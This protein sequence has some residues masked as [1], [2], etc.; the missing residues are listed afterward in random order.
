MAM[1]MARIQPQPLY[2]FPAPASSSPPWNAH[3][4]KLSKWTSCTN[5]NQS[6]T[7]LVSHTFEKTN[8]TILDL[9]HLVRQSLGGGANV[10]E[11]TSRLLDQVITSIDL[12]SFCG[13]E[14]ELIAACKIPHQ[15]D[16]KKDRSKRKAKK[17]T[18]SVDYF[19]KV[20]LYANS[21]LPPHLTTLK[22]YPPTYPLLQLA[23]KYSRRVYD[24]PSGHERHSY[25]DSD[26]LHGT[27]A[28]VVKSL[29]IDD[30]NTIVFAIRGTQS[31]LDWAVNVRAAPVPPMGFLDDPS[32]CCHS[33]F[34]SVARKM[35]APVAAR[36]RSLLEEDPSRMSYSLIFTG[37]SAGGAVAS[38]L[39]LHLLSE[40][41]A[42]Q[43]ELIHLRGC[44]KHIHCVTFGAPP[45]S[46]R[47]LQ[48]SPTA[49][50]S[51]SMFFAFINEGDPVSRA[52]KNYFISLLDLYVSPAPGSVLALYDKKKKAAPIYWRTPSSDLSLAGRL[53]LLR[54]RDQPTSQPVFVAPPV[55]GGPPALPP[56]E[57]VDACGI[58]DTE[59]RGVVFGDPVMHFMDLYSRRIDALARDA[60]TRR[61]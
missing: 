26:W 8:A 39:Y 5:L 42:V 2:P 55:P 29:P 30:M 37:H 54:P 53:V 12:G 24:K 48:L 21:R 1:S 16:E 15:S 20:Y 9:E 56:R 60:L 38:L 31:F 23:A 36:L 47:P 7:S 46:L 51:K 6:M 40:S 41:P 50:R 44:F 35:V 28:M 13:R 25:V 49:Q 27:K 59:L 14:T 19:S 45:I 61:S 18:R 58:V 10:K 11:A 17:P 3:P 22:F 43:S 33:G 34:L 4:P 52:D 32:N 57:N